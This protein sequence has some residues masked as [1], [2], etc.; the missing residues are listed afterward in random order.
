MWRAVSRVPAPSTY[1]RLTMRN[2]LI[3]D[4][5]CIP[6]PFQGMQCDTA[7]AGRRAARG[8]ITTGPAL[9]P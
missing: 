4:V 3:N 6:T 8:H 9:N 1:S 2:K 5:H 7:P